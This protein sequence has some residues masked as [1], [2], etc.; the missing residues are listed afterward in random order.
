LSIWHSNSVTYSQ[1]YTLTDCFFGD[2]AN[3]TSI[4]FAKIK[5]F[6]AIDLKI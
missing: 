1:I 2:F 6:V 4:K 3:I 5:D